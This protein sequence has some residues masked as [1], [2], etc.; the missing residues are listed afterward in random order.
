[1]TWFAFKGYNNGAAI[2]LAGVQEKEAVSLG[3]HG[4]PT[5]LQ[6]QAHPNSV[7]IL[8]KLTVNAL[9]ADYKYAVASGEQ[10]GGPNANILNPVNDA[11]GAAQA[12]AGAIPGVKDIGDFFR[13]LTEGSTW[14]RVGEVAAG[15][16]LLYIGL[17]A[18]VTPGGVPVASRGVK[19]TA[20]SIIRKTPARVTPVG[21][22]AGRATRSGV[23]GA[24]EHHIQRRERAAGI[25]PARSRHAI[26]GGTG[27]VRR[28]NYVIKRGR[29]AVNQ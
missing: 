20:G 26:A 9:I 25:R 27:A 1:M 10:P 29:H 6:A 4:Y 21:R 11:K 18:A 7:N 24:A 15:M 22:A 28:Q 3:F 19:Q 17:K 5:Q 8:Q 23:R 13:R 14:V 12:A 2:D 16:L